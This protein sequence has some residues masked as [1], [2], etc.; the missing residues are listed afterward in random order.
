VPGATLKV[1]GT[2]RAPR[3]AGGSV[4]DIEGSLAGH[5]LDVEKDG[6]L[7]HQNFV[8]DRDR[9]LDLFEIPRDGSKAWIQALLYDGVISRSG[10]LARLLRPVAIV[11][12]P[13]V[14]PE[15]WTGARAVWEEATERMGGVTGYAFELTEQPAAGSIA[16]T[17]ELNPSL[18][19]AGRFDWSGTNNVIERGTIQFRTPERLR[20]FSIVLH[21]LTHGFGLSHS[22][23]VSDLMHPSAVATAHSERE[24]A[25]VSAV[26][27]RPANT[28]FEDNVR[29]ATSAL[30]AASVSRSY[31]CG[32]R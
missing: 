12:G 17:V 26:K 15:V 9:A 5:A 8:P 11:R 3:T 7:V 14:P 20:Q 24:L 22:D 1:D 32:D 4:F 23:R 13:S 30:A 21:E 28:A 31:A 6:F 27:R 10:T 29:N 19:S 18:S 25:V 2:L 16:Y